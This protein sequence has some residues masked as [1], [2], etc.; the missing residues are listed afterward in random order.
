LSDILLSH[1]VSIN[2]FIDLIIFLLLLIAFYHAVYILKNY[3]K[4]SVTEYQYNLQKKSYLVASVIFFAFIVKIM[5]L[6]FFTYTLEQL[7]AIVPGAMCGVGVIESNGYGYG[8]LALKIVI[9]MLMMMWIPLH[10]QD[11]KWKN[12]PFFKH[13]LYL[14]G[15][16]FILICFELLLEILFFTNIST[17]TPVLCCSSIYKASKSSNLLPFGLSTTQIAILFYLLYIS[18]VSFCY[19]KKRVLLFVSSLFYTYISYYTIVYFFSSYIYE[20]PTHK[21]PFCMLQRDYYYIGY[22][23]FGCLFIATFYAL[24]SSIYRFENK[25]FY[26]SILFYTIFVALC[27]VNFIYY[28]LSHGVFL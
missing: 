24:S 4:N 1:E 19:F 11:Q 7:S 8:V 28:T 20:L 22:F 17:Q 25:D 13:K 10:N 12:H 26:K 9:A 15:V 5:V 18:V 21:C 14:F 27:S 2:I 3:H 16:I 6:V 23:I